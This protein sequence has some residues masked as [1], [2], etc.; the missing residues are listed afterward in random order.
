MHVDNTILRHNA[1]IKADCAVRALATAFAL[2]YRTMEKLAYAELGYRYK[3]PNTGVMSEL[4]HL[5]LQREEF[6]MIGQDFVTTLHNLEVAFPEGTYLVQPRGHIFALVDGIIYDG[7]YG[8]EYEAMKNKRFGVWYLY[9]VDTK[10]RFD[11][12]QEITL[13][14]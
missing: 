8:W 1:H 11:F 9:A 12:I 6:R 5:Y 10:R 14:D 13:G 3:G 4:L 2:P 7:M